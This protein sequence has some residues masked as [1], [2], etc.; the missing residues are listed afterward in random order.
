MLAAV[1]MHQS[2]TMSEDAAIQV[3]V[4]GPYH[5]VSQE[6]ILTLEPG[7]PLEREVV[8]GVADDLVEHRG[9]R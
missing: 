5:F 4:D 8:V 3:L 6:P 7:L 2:G 1:A 9:L